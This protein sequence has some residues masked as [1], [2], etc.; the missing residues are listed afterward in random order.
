MKTTK[1]ILIFNFIEMEDKKMKSQFQFS[2]NVTSF[3]NEN[4]MT[5]TVLCYNN[6]KDMIHELFRN[7]SENIDFSDFT[8]PDIVKIFTNLNEN[9]S[10]IWKEI[11]KMFNTSY[12]NQ[13]DNQENDETNSQEEDDKFDDYISHIEDELDD[14]MDE[15]IPHVIF[16]KKDDTIVAIVTNTKNEFVFIKKGH[17]IPDLA[18]S[19][20]Y[21]L[22]DMVKQTGD[23]DIN[24]DIIDQVEKDELNMIDMFMCNLVINMKLFSHYGSD[25]VQDFGS[26]FDSIFE[27]DS[28]N[29]SSSIFSENYSRPRKKG[30]KGKK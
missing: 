7:I 27:S 16:K 10:D 13:T 9:E 19:M 18:F 6:T 11:D 29:S 15:E 17:F 21:D 30:K 25:K 8:E 28:D 20:A 4:I 24:Y 5:V 12:S 22:V 3:L 23:S 2:S 1:K 14:K 26:L